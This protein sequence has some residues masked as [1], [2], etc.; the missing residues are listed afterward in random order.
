MTQ[1]RTVLI[2]RHFGGPEVLEFYTEHA[3]SPGPGEALVQ[4]RAAGIN[5]IDARRMTGEFHKD[6]PLTFGTEFAGTIQALGADTAPWE[7][8]DAVLGF[9]GGFTHATHIVVPARNLVAKPDSLSWEIAG[10]LAGAAQ[11][12]AT[13]LRELAL[14]ASGSLLI[15]GGSGGVGSIT[16]QLAVRRGLTVVATASAANQNYLRALGA[17]P[18]EYGPGLTARITAV[19]PTPFT[20][21]VDM[22]GNTEAIDASLA[23]VHP[24][25]TVATIAGRP[26]DSPRVRPILMERNR[27]DLQEV[28]D[29]VADGTLHWEVSRSY[30]L[31]DAVSAYTDILSGHTRGKSVLTVPAQR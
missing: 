21:S 2:A 27:E 12:A 18:V 29:G 4:V 28:V 9:S 6:L 3:P 20:A 24:D 17:I 23:L 1:T 8:G 10:S 7:V 11:T 30:P 31:L 26:V 13:I 16:V 25:G 15:H 19:H 22:I 14:P 5:P